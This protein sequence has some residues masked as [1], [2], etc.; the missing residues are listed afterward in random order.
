[1]ILP[2]IGQIGVFDD[3]RR[4]RCMLAKGRA[5]I[6]FA[7]VSYYAGRW[8]LSLNVQAADLHPAHQHPARPDDDR[9]G[10]VG[11]DRG[12]TSFLV[13]ATA[14]GQ[15]VARIQDAPKALAA[16]MAQQRHLAKKLS[17]K[18]KDHATAAK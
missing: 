14:E 8:W 15:E 16:G 6:L 4:L 17:R 1:V 7:T 9:G 12:L 18:K 5:K 11:V 2:G 10:W 13:A 3:T